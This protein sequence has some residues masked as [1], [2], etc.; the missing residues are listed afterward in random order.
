MISQA[1]K[2]DPENLTAAYSHDEFRQAWKRRNVLSGQNVRG[3]HLITRSAL[4]DALVGFHLQN[5]CTV[6]NEVPI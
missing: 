5:Y 1:W 4:D 3:K 2:A 6:Y